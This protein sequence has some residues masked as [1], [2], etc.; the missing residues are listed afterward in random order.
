M[1]A[2]HVQRV[3]MTAD[4]LGGV[5]TYTVELAHALR[6]RDIEVHVATMGAPLT[7]AQ[8]AQVSG[9]AIHESAYRLEWMQAAQNDV[10]YAGTW[11]MELETQIRPDI[12]HLN[13]FA[14]GALPFIA[15]KLVV[16]HS[17]VLSWWRAVHGQ[18]APAEW[19]C[20]REMVASGLQGADL[21]AAPTAAMLGTLVHNYGF[22][23]GG[24]VIPNGRTAAQFVRRDKEP[25]IMAAGRLWDA[26]KN[27][28]ALECVAPEL[29]WPVRVAGSHA[30]PDGGVRAARNVQNLGELT[31]EALS[32]QLG[33]AAIY[34]L[35]ARYE[36]F[37]LSALEAG[38]GGCALVLGDIA[39][40]REVWEDAAL[41][42]SPGDHKALRSTLARLI[43]DARLRTAM[44]DRAHSCALRYTPQRMAQHYVLAY[45][46]V[47][48]ARSV[49][50][51]AVSS[52]IG[53]RV[54]A[55]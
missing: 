15:P 26:A 44:A 23:R 25:F 55:S 7:S 27:L 33:H 14:F 34:A 22:R 4:T 16:A 20:Y 19:N 17:C 6:A 37:G 11:L 52:T 35:P 8:R 30:H 9:I 39:S 42:V 5:W 40:L 49:L 47:L 31:C 24:I 54:C 18:A 38:L 53:E 29:A 48:R 41:Y 10:T 21:V 46:R 3:L 12:V 32:D 45:D 13:Q 51:T 43:T 2:D 1:A 36:P 50:R 28:E